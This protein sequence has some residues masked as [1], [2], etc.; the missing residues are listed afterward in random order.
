[1]VYLLK[2]KRRPQGKCIK[3]DKRNAKIFRVFHFR[4]KLW[5][6]IRK[7][8]SR[9]PLKKKKELGKLKSGANRIIE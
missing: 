2:V 5:T 1:M 3:K 6:T 8:E 4:L 9:R 7:L